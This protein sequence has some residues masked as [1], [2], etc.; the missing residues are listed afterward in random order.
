MPKVEQVYGISETLAVLRDLDRAVYLEA[1]KSMRAAA[2]PLRAGVVAR[3]PGNPPLSG[4]ARGRTAWSKAGTAVRTQ[5]GGRKPKAK[6]QWPLIRVKVQ[7]AGAAL[8]DIAGRGSL[9][10]RFVSNLMGAGYPMPSRAAWPA[11][12]ATMPAVQVAVRKAVED[13]SVK[14]NRQLAWKG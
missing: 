14:A 6:E 13:A 5:L 7:G 10:G 8:Y 4:M 1:R 3:L 11:A 9:T 2:E 12:E